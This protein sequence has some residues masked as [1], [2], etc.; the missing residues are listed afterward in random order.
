MAQPAALADPIAEQT[1]QGLALAPTPGLGA[2]RV[3]V[4]DRA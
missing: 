4:S 1:L 2:T 3:R